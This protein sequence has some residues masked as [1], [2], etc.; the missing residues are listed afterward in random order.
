MEYCPNLTVFQTVSINVSIK[1]GRVKKGN[2]QYVAS[3]DCPLQN[4]KQALWFWHD[5]ETDFCSS[6]LTEESI[7]TLPRITTRPFVRRSLSQK[8]P[9]H[10]Q[11]ILYKPLGRGDGV[12][13]EGWGT[14]WQAKPQVLWGTEQPG[15]QCGHCTRLCVCVRKYHVSPQPPTLSARCGLCNGGGRGVTICQEVCADGRGLYIG[16]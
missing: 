10:P 4:T 14:K 16:H 11:F 6:L 13:V 9:Q 12:G 8:L 2:T 5:G 15:W 1:R 3:T 7:C